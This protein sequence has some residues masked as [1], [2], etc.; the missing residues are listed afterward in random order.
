MWLEAK[1]R[2]YI[3]RNDVSQ[4]VVP[5]VVEIKASSDPRDGGD[6]YTVGRMLADAIHRFDVADCGER[7]WTVADAESAGLAAAW[8][9]LVDDNGALRQDAFETI[10][11]PVV[12]LYVLHPN[13]A[14][15]RL[16]VMDAV[17]SL[18]GAESL[19]LAQYH[20]TE[21]AETEFEVLGFRPLPRPAGYNT[22]DPLQFMARE[23]ALS[24][25]RISSYPKD[26]PHGKLEHQEW[27]ER[28]G[29]WKGLG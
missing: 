16:A 17:C 20:T 4:F 11:D 3:T 13:F 8:A 18:F 26:S 19:I 1:N 24:P 27:V 6:P 25:Y 7:A 14:E 23:N 9:F 29:P 5:W 22:D 28:Q 21:Y 15:L 2:V 12:Y 10:V